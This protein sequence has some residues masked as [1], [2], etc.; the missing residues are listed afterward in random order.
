MGGFGVSQAMRPQGIG[1]R[2]FAVAMEWINAPVY[3][4][5]V[6]LIGPQPGDRVLELGFGTGALLAML[7]PG[8][9]GGLL[10]GVDPSGLMVRQAR[11]R[12]AR[13]ASTVQLDIRQVTDQD[14]SWPDAYF[15]HVV[16][17]HSFQFWA[18]PDSTLQ[19]I[20]A[21]LRPG[22][23]LILVL[24]SHSRHR[25]A[26]LPNSISRSADEIGGTLAALQGGGLDRVKRLPNVGSSAVLEGYAGGLKR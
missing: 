1:G 22:G 25:P 8:M 7:A 23:R 13:F 19:R 14:L 21:L 20:R 2:V 10:A 4:R 3:D 6:E 15:T 5:V 26:W 16:A 18:D 24:R 12:L 9:T 17:L 11:A